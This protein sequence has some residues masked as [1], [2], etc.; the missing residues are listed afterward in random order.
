MTREYSA[1]AHSPLKPGAGFVRPRQKLPDR[2]ELSD[3]ALAV[4]TD[5]HKVSV[6]SVRS[7][8]PLDKAN[9]RMIHYGVRLLVVLD[10][11]DQVAGLL[12]ANDILGEKPVCHLQT[13][14]GTHADILVRDIMTPQRDI[15]ALAIA[16]VRAAK[17]GHI[18][19]SL[20][21]KGRQHALVVEDGPQGRQALCGLFSLTQIARQLGVPPTQGFDIKRLFA[22]IDAFLRQP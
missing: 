4:M 5:L 17:V 14:G 6:V 2:V 9:E 10:D 19:A 3:P 15:E 12:T 16:E 22:D 8:T 21:Q 7:R 20:K 13:M 18:I 11:N 1:L